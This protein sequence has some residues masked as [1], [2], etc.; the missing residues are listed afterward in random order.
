MAQIAILNKYRNELGRAYRKM[1]DNGT[2]S[3]WC[4]RS[5]MRSYS[6]RPDNK[7]GTINTSTQDNLILE[8][9]GE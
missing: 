9:H 1:Y 6:C 8:I 7:S 3:E 5:C 2:R 4:N